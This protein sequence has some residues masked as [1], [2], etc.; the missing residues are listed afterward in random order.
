MA[1]A[2]DNAD[3]LRR[4]LL[5]S[6][7]F[8]AAWVEMVHRM[9]FYLM[10]DRPDTYIEQ[11]VRGARSDNTAV[12]PG[13]CTAEYVAPTHQRRLKGFVRMNA[14]EDTPR[15]KSRA[16]SRANK[17]RESFADLG[18]EFGIQVR[19]VYCKDIGAQKWTVW[20]GYDP[21]RGAL[22]EDGRIIRR[23]AQVRVRGRKDKRTK[24]DKTGAF[25]TAPVS[26]PTCGAEAGKPCTFTRG[27]NVGDPTPKIHKAREESLAAMAKKETRPPTEDERSR[28]WERNADE[29]HLER[30]EDTG[31]LSVESFVATAT[32]A[33]RAEYEAWVEKGVEQ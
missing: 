18:G 5:D 25:E 10:G 4:E 14:Y 28:W 19:R 23:Q 20:V 11:T 30:V 32:P 9:S 15:G 31:S 29:R 6:G 22:G 21:N 24:K 12:K 16:H 27:A 17:Y 2:E 26:C 3:R 8:P 33:K 1:D 13:E 7:E